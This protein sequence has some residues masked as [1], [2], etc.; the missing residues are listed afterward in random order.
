MS[1]WSRWFKGFTSGRKRGS[2]AG[3]GA[4]TRAAQKRADDA[5]NDAKSAADKASKAPAPKG[6]P[7]K[8]V[9]PFQIQEAYDYAA[10]QREE[11]ESSAELAASIQGELVSFLHENAEQLPAF[12]SVA[13]QVFELIEKPDF[14]VQRLVTLIHRDSVMSTEVLR[15]A[16]SPMFRTQKEVASVRDAIVHLGAKQVANVA[17]AV[18]TRSLFDLEAKAGQQ[19]FGDLWHELWLHSM[20][21]ATT[22]FWVAD[23]LRLESQQYA[24]LAGMLHDIGKTISLWGL[25]KLVFSQAV[26]LPLPHLT[27]S[28]IEANHVE[29]GRVVSSKWEIPQVLSDTVKFHHEI[30]AEQD[31][32]IP[33]VALTSALNEIRRNPGYDRAQE[34]EVWKAVEILKLQPLRVRGIVTRLRES[35]QIAENLDRK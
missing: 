18:S 23:E 20:T 1:W 24:Y 5:Q 13:S 35:Q 14:D 25:S 3:G 19:E 17:A 16:N 21:C 11:L 15:I 31:P 33:A 28:I 10:D 9:P 29:A 22:S 2:G 8:E 12:P 4:G 30:S 6:R 7:A 26:P 34:D 27:R 32:L